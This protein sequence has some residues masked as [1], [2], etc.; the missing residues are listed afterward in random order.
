MAETIWADAEIVSSAFIGAEMFSV[1]LRRTAFYDCKLDSVNFRNGKLQDVTFV[2]C[3]L[4]DVDFGDATLVN[5]TFAGTVLDGVRLNKAHMKKVDLRGASAIGIS[6]GVESLKG[7]T[8][9]SLQL[10]DLAPLLAH[11]MGIIVKER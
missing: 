7:A 10:L 11:A 2:D 5:A 9:N 3:L 1:E 4:K 8:V 6:E